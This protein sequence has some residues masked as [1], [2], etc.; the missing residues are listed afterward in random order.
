MNKELIKALKTLGVPVAMH[1]YEGSEKTYLTYS[2]TDEGAAEMADDEEFAT[3]FYYQIDVYSNG[4]Y[5]D[6]VKTLKKTMKQIGG[7]RIGEF[8]TSDLQDSYRR[9][10]RFKFTNLT[11]H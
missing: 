11:Q 7:T 6:L 3:H 4:D 2:Q 10:L 1:Q 9:T 8:D 5:T